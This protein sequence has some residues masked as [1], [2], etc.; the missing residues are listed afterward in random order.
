MMFGEC[1]VCGCDDLHAC[2]GGCSWIEPDL[3]SACAFGL[4]EVEKWSLR[5]HDRR[6]PQHAWCMAAAASVLAGEEPPTWPGGRKATGASR[7]ETIGRI[8]AA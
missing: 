7:L 5:I 3:C 2:A 6:S 1:C 4:A 8:L